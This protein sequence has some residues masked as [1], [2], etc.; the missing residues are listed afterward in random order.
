MPKQIYG[1]ELCAVPGQTSAMIDRHVLQLVAADHILPKL[2]TRSFQTFQRDRLVEQVERRE[3]GSRRHLP[4]RQEL[5]EVIPHQ[6]HLEV[7]FFMLHHIVFGADMRTG[8]HVVG[9]EACLVGEV[10]V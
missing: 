10:G 1:S 3:P 7:F 2:C 8:L 9:G 5:G 4:R 6:W